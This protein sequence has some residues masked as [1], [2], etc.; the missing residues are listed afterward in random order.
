MSDILFS[1]RWGKFWPKGFKIGLFL[2]IF[3]AN[4]TQKYIDVLHGMVRDYNIGL[5]TNIRI[6]FE[7]FRKF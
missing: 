5:G 6:F 4:S 1:F 2:D 3:S 7:I